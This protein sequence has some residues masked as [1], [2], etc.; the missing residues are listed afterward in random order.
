MFNS[1][2]VTTAGKLINNTDTTLNSITNSVS[3]M[4]EHPFNI[5]QFEV[6]SHLTFSIKHGF[7]N[8]GM[9]TTI[10]TPTTLYRYVT[11][12]ENPNKTKNKNLKQ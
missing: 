10:G 8:Y 7:S 11:L 9:C 4:V 2:F 3:I 12:I 5:S 1:S 6:F